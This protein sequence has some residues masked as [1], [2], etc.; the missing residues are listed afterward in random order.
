[1]LTCEGRALV[2]EIQDRLIE[3]YVQQ[4]EVEWFVAATDINGPEMCSRSA[5]GKQPAT[6]K[7]NAREKMHQ[8]VG[9]KL[10]HGW[11]PKAPTRGLLLR[12]KQNEK[13]NSL[14]RECYRV[15]GP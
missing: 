12:D 10:H 2:T 5:S 7:V 14:T 3:L 6:G 4:D 15:V 9:V 11:M 8:R 13:P 1:M